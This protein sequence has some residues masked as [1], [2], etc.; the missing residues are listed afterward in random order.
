MQAYDPKK[1]SGQVTAGYGGGWEW[2]C[3]G[4]KCLPGPFASKARFTGWLVECCPQ[5]RKAM[6][7]GAELIE[8]YNDYR[9]SQGLPPI[10]K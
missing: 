6:A 3:N 5:S 8:S 10:T 4:R 9:D 7:T 2:N 1:V